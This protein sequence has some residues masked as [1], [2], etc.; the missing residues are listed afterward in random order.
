MFKRFFG[1]VV[2]PV[3]AGALGTGLTVAMAAPTIPPP[4]PQSAAPA[5]PTAGPVAS[6]A[7]PSTP[8]AVTAVWSGRQVVR[9][10]R[11]LPVLGEFETRTDLWVLAR[12]TRQGDRWDVEQTACRITVAK[13]VGVRASFPQVAVAALPKV[14]FEITRWADGVLHPTPWFSGWN[15]ADLDNDGWPGITLTVSAPLCS[16]R[17]AIASN[18]Y[19]QGEVRQANDRGLAMDIK[20]HVGQRT[21]ESTGWCLKL[22]DEQTNDAFTG[23]A[24][25]EPLPAGSGCEAVNALPALGGDPDD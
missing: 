10:T 8:P 20:V 24:L 2:R 19:N 6:A 17:L 21:L 25:Y 3:V 9:G 23:E 14:K 18:A 4:P 1:R 11:E 15:E 7:P 13:V 5:A 16:G 12:V 22:A